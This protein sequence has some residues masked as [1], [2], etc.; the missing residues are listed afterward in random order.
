MKIGIDKFN[1][2]KPID[3]CIDFEFKG[4]FPCNTGFAIGE[5][6]DSELYEYVD[7]EV[8]DN[9]IYPINF[10]CFANSIGLSIDELWKFNTE[11]LILDLVDTRKTFLDVIPNNVLNKLRS[12]KSKL[13]LNYGFEEYS[14][15]L[16]DT[17]LYLEQYLVYHLK[18]IGIDPTNVWYTDSNYQLDVIHSWKNDEKIN[19]SNRLQSINCFSQNFTANSFMYERD[20]WKLTPDQ[21]ESKKNQK[22]IKKY[23]CYNRL[24]KEHR[25]KMVDWLLEKQ[26]VKDGYV[27]FPPDL[28]LDY[29]NFDDN[30][31]YFPINHNHYNSSF[32]SIVT[33]SN[34]RFDVR[35]KDTV[36]EEG[37]P[38][39]R[40]SYFSSGA[41]ESR[42]L[43][44]KTWKPIFNLHP[45]VILGAPDSISYLDERGFDIFIDLFPGQDSHGGYSGG[46]KYDGQHHGNLRFDSLCNSI[47]DFLKD[48]TIEQL[49]KLRKDI[50][51][52]LL[53]NYN[54]FWGDFTRYVKSDFYSKL[55]KIMGD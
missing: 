7:T 47:D 27:S 37:N 41:V 13:L 23:I 55:Q 31:A 33:E 32:F 49:E 5:F 46:P 14:A 29:T 53:A 35:I 22:L 51:P 10:K 25:K 18:R 11:D 43:T 39:E 9:F 2:D 44:E 54:N 15:R 40:G 4:K 1:G 52:R 24:Y 28:T 34:F 48:N 42:Y 12:G 26:Y 50:F 19:E 17:V 20:I 38:T 36:D 21:I 3:N 16:K 30:W 8:E 6:L 45:V